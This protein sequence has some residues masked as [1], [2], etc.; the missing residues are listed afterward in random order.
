MTTGTDFVGTLKMNMN[1]VQSE[2]KSWTAKDGTTRYYINYISEL[3]DDYREATGRELH[4]YYDPMTG[5]SA[6]RVRAIIERNILPHTKAYIDGDGLVHIYG[7]AIVGQG[8]GMG[9]PSLIEKAINWKFGYCTED[10]R[11]IRVEKILTTHARWL[12]NYGKMLSDGDEAKIGD[13]VEIFKGRKEVGKVFTITKISHYQ[14]NRWAKPSIYL[15]GEDGFK[16][17]AE[18]CYI[19]SVGYSY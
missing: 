12:D 8:L 6:G 18:N 9:L 15:Y 3:I 11:Q 2:L 17:N 7:W 10:E 4:S 1:S 5:A 19:R 14:Y 16:V 13:S